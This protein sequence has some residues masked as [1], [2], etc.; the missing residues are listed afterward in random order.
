MPCTAAHPEPYTMILWP[1]AVLSSHTWSH[2]RSE[3]M[4]AGSNVQ[5][6][7]LRLGRCLLRFRPSTSN[8]TPSIFKLQNQRLTLDRNSLNLGRH[9]AAFA[10]ETPRPI[11]LHPSTCRTPK[12]PQPVNTLFSVG[13]LC[14]S[15]AGIPQHIT[16]FAHSSLFFGITVDHV[17]VSSTTALST[18][19]IPAPSLA[20]DNHTQSHSEHEDTAARLKAF[21][22]Q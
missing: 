6:R 22:D 8:A 13:G 17:P 16:D 18:S 2:P 1:Y 21:T 19:R 14:S 11:H 9:G 4:A 10:S 20:L 5:A 3:S 12:H 15:H 7:D